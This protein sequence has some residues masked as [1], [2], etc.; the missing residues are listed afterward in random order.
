[1]QHELTVSALCGIGRI[2]STK[3]GAHKWLDSNGVSHRIVSVR[4]G[5]AKAVALADLP[6]PE[7]LAYLARKLELADLPYGER[8]DT[9]WEAYFSAPK[10]L[11]EAADNRAEMVRAALSLDGAT[12]GDRVAAIT[13]LFE[14]ATPSVGT[15]KRY[16]KLVKGVDPANFEPTLLPRYRTEGA[17]KTRV[18]DA[19]WAHFMR[20]IKDA[21]PTFPLVSAWRD[22]ADI[23]AQKEWVWPSYPT[24]NR[25][26]NALPKPQRDAARYGRGETAKQLYQPVRRDKTTICPLEWVS[27]DGRTQDYWTDMG[28]GKP[29]RITM[30]TLVDVASNKIIGYELAPSENADATA[31]LIRKSCENYGIFDRLYT[32]N[33]SAFAGHRVAGG[34][35]HKFRN[36]STNKGVRPIGICKILDI[37]I[38]FALPG[39]AQAKIAE[40][41]FASISRT[42]DDRP[43]FAGAHAGHNPGASPTASV[44]PVPIETVR[45]VVEREVIRHNSQTGRRSDGANGRSYDAV[46]DAG[47]ANRTT[48]KMTARQLYLA[49]LDYRPVAVD[50]VGQMKIDGWVYG[51]PATQIELLG[52]HKSGQ[53]ILLGRDPDDLAAPAI[54]FDEDHKLICEGILPVASGRYDSVDGIRDASRNRKVARR[55]AK[56]ADDANCYADDTEFAANLRA[57]SAVHAKSETK[58]PAPKVVEGHFSNPLQDSPVPEQ[59]RSELSQEMLANFDRANAKRL[60]R[61]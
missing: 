8:D 7:R 26:W 42:I 2:P 56:R 5:H 25:R 36:S 1:M 22:V 27:L 18:S 37:K 55:M 35:N 54:A 23:A 4:G 47:I 3:A 29:V 40:R 39:N 53:K 14:D 38:K 9:A 21:A 20:T 33:G 50:R 12:W 43:E 57:L 61:G 10:S 52:Y 6:R 59:Q 32:D 30:L 28:D 24:I 41:I 60:N 13:G 44:V 31:R 19:A 48:R 51:G 34:T 16:V 46:F 17:P 15:L 58:T 45:H 49:S 11:R